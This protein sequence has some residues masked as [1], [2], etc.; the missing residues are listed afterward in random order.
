MTLCVLPREA[1]CPPP[2]AEE[3]AF[4]PYN[5]HRNSA[6]RKRKKR[7]PLMYTPTESLFSPLSLFLWK[8]S[9]H[10]GTRA[11]CSARTDVIRG[12]SQSEIA[13]KKNEIAS[14][15]PPFMRKDVTW[16]GR[17]KAPATRTCAICPGHV[18]L[19]ERSYPTLATRAVGMA[20][21]CPHWR[22]VGEN[23]N[24]KWLLLLYVD[25]C[26]RWFVNEH[27][28]RRGWG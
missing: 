12:I 19:Y 10:Q 22:D 20:D 21:F 8:T 13:K 6:W 26:F 17:L 23:S 15:T 14:K 24:N 27:A 5:K 3:L 1:S 2:L 9:S 18:T 16:N 25:V 28:T 7:K 11:G 4:H